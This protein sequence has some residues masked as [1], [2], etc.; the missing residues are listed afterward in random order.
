MIQKKQKRL[1]TFSLLK[2]LCVAEQFRQWMRLIHLSLFSVITRME[3][4][5]VVQ[6]AQMSLCL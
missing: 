1:S 4:A 3:E 6:M 5:L 2:W